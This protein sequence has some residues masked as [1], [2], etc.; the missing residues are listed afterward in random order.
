MAHVRTP[1][2]ALV[3]LGPGVEKRPELS[4]IA[5]GAGTLGS[6]VFFLLD[7]VDQRQLLEFTAS[8]D[9]GIIPYPPI[10]LNSRLC[11][12]NKLFE[13]IVA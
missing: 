3:F 5:A 13:F 2:I 12:P 1:D 8:A 9:I 7:A 11:T 6:R 4:E 10:D